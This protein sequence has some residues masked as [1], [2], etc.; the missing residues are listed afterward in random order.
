MK[1]AITSALV[2][3]FV[4]LASPAWAHPPS[5]II[6]TFDKATKHLHAVIKHNVSNVNNHYIKK[7]DVGLN[8]KEILTQYI[9]R[10]DNNVSQTVDYLIPDAKTGDTISVEGYCSISGKLEKEIKVK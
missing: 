5:D 4:V 8:D 3:Y 9:S 7:V 1:K 6:I 2:C 10:Q